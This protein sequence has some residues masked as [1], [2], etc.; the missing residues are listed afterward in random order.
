MSAKLLL[1]AGGTGGHI[2]P[3]ISF[4]KWIEKN[5]PESHVSYVCGDRPLETEI[6]GASGIEPHRLKVGGSPFSGGALARITRGYGQAAAIFS[7]IGLLKSDRPD[8]VLLFG[9][10]VSFPFLMAA[11]ILKIPVIAHEQNAYAGR[12][13]RL[14][15]KIGV[16]VLSGWAECAP[17]P[18]SKFTRIGV[19]VR[20]F[21]RMPR[22][23]AWKALE[24]T[25]SVPAGPILLVFSGSLGSG[26]IRDMVTEISGDE[27][28]TGWT[29]I[30]PAVSEKLEI[31]N[32][33]VFFMAKIWDTSPLYSLADMAAVRGGG[34]TLTEVAM[35]G[36]PALV[37]PWSGASDNHQYHNA[38]SFSS[39]NRAMI[40][41]GSEGRKGFAK[42]LLRLYD[43]LSDKNEKQ[44]EASHT[45]AGR[46]C[47]DLWLAISSHM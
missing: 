36:I 16:E 3:A 21:K 37:I 19:P 2:W 39:E 7:A 12:V 23:A 6:Y 22:D 13:T 29:F 41:D 43:I 31:V 28:F 14:A 8:I 38:V 25:G 32:K 15:S 44:R 45:G 33:N 40:W 47:E 42:N 27:D 17:L 20:E 11:K 18:A 1:A 9:G 10:Y 26:L 30:V 34:S 24:L 35:L 4:G 46:I 5:K